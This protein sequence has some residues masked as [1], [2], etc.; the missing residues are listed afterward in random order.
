MVL[1]GYD[2]GSPGLAD[3]P[4]SDD[5]LRLLLTTLLWS[6]DDTQALRAA[7]EVL[8][9]QVD[10]VLDTWYGYV[11]ANEHLVWFFAGQDGAP[12]ARYLARVRDR[13]AQWVRDLCSRD[14]DRSWLAYQD[15]I[16]RRHTPEG[17]NATDGVDSPADHIPLRYLIAFVWPIT[18]TIRPFLGAKGHAA[19]QV[20][21]MHQAW[22]KA[23]V[24]SVTLWSRRYSERLW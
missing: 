11:G 22:F 21:A 10:Q 14:F 17:K 24:L 6:E 5:E 13:F 16:S 15:E 8:A 18:A 7:G 12:D 19:E 4:V 9:D 20:D 1:A 2:Y 3:S 23:V